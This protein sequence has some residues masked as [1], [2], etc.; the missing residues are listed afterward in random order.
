MAG[1]AH[2]ADE[3]PGTWIGGILTDDFAAAGTQGRGLFAVEAQGRYFDI[4]SGLNQ[5]LLR[6]GVGYKLSGSLQAWVGYGRF[7]VRPGQGSPVDE[8]RYFQQLNWSAG[9]YLG[10]EL[11]VRARLLQ[12]SVTNGDDVALVA[13]LLLDYSRALNTANPTTLNLRLEPFYDLRDTDWGGKAGL[14]QNR[15]Y[16]GL[17]WQLSQH[18]V[19]ETGYMKQFLWRDDARNLS[20]HLLVIQLRAKL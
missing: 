1:A 15:I 4:G 6:S 9:E 7:R 2:A 5:Y 12:R 14:T 16:A 3:S 18:Y 19:L 8:N 10:G 13:R 11:K 20:N 17:G